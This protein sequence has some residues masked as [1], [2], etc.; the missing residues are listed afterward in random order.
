MKYLIDF[1][2]VDSKLF[3][4]YLLKKLK[5]MKHINIL[6]ESTLQGILFYECWEDKGIR[7]CYIPECGYYADDEK[8]LIKLFQELAGK[9]VDD[10][11]CEFMINL[12]AHDYE[13]IQTFHM[14]QFGTMSE[15]CVKKISDTS[16]TIN[17]LYEI[18]VLDKND[19]ENMWD[20]IWNNTNAIV[21]HL[22]KSPV[23]YPGN[24]FT[25]EVYKE[26]FMDDETELIAAFSDDKVIGIIEW[27]R[28]RNAK[29]AERNKLR[30]AREKEENAFIQTYIVSDKYNVFRWPDKLDIYKLNKL[31]RLDAQGIHDEVLADEIGLILYLRCKY[32][33]SDMELMKKNQI[34][35]HG[36]NRILD[37]ETDFRQC[38]CG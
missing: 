7:H 14:M 4:K 37:G 31:Y 6:Q 36:C 10:K 26:F 35:C 34:R 9:V 23:F 15:K 25:Q 19:I 27:N 21:E 12:Y 1:P 2:I 3:E 28:E 13:S 38:E 29:Q 11:K 20:E 17:S 24:E 5:D 30:I 16:N 8:I 33:K 18:R 22:R 32:G